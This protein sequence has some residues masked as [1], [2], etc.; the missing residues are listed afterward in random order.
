MA[1]LENINHRPAQFEFFQNI[2]FIHNLH[3]KSVYSFPQ[4]FMSDGGP[5]Y[6]VTS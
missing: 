4:V 6:E 5:W 3:R 1:V 2:V